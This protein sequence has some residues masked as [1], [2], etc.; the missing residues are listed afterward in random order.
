MGEVRIESMES[1]IEE[2][3]YYSKIIERS[4]TMSFEESRPKFTEQLWMREHNQNQ[5]KILEPNNPLM[6]SFQDALQAHLTRISNTLSDEIFDIVRT[7]YLNILQ[8]K[9]TSIF[10]IETR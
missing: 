3:E 10:I 1:P 8:T 6:K 7:L 9:T 4:L 2:Y 5:F